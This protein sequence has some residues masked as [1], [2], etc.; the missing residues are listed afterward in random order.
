MIVVT[1]VSP[2]GAQFLSEQLN[3]DC[4]PFMNNFSSSTV[5]SPFHGMARLAAILSLAL[6]LVLGQIS[7]AMSE[8]MTYELVETV[9]PQTL[10]VVVGKSIVLR[11]PKPLKRASLA[12]GEIADTL[13]PCAAGTAELPR[14][15]LPRAL[16]LQGMRRSA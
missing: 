4:V 1:Y 14:H 11:S 6:C 3:N 13:V 7:P 2:R 15:S 12:N 9:N 8:G 5:M 16:Y 10:T